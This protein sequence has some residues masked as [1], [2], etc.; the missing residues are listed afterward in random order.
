MK[1]KKHITRNYMIGGLAVFLQRHICE[2]DL[3][4]SEKVMASFLFL[5]CSPPSSSLS[6]LL[7]E[8]LFLLLFYFSVF[9]GF[10][11]NLLV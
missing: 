7:H 4:T 10:G 2:M 8:V 6:F 5:S 3:E 9:C 11:S 1:K